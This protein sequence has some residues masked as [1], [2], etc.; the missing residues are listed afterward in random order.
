MLKKTF[1]LLK[2]NPKLILY[3]VI[4]IVINTLLALGVSGII[5]PEKIDEGALNQVAGMWIIIAVIS[6]IFM[7]GF[8]CMLASAVKNGKCT[9]KDFAYGLKN[10][11]GKMI[12]SFL[13]ILIFL[14][15][16]AIILIMITV[17]FTMAASVGVSDEFVYSLVM[18]TAIG[19]MTLFL[20]PLFMLWYPAMFIDDVKVM[21]GLRRGARTSKKC[22]WTLVL[23]VFITVIP[24]LTYSLITAFTSTAQVLSA[25][26][27]VFMLVNIIFSFILLVFTFVIYK[28]KNYV[29]QQ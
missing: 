6:I 10:E 19:L 17:P 29:S 8:G 22:Y 26:Y 2:K 12:L 18:I 1:S 9:N 16:F 24:S 3:Y 28:E 23:A 5:N 4:F 15:G 7:A 25:G 21:E 14:L 13:L 11:I 27:W 20:Y